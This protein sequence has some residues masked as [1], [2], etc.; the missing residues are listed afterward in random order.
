MNKSQFPPWRNVKPFGERRPG[1]Q[2]S[3]CKPGHTRTE[4]GTERVQSSDQFSLGRPKKAPLHQIL[5]TNWIFP[6]KKKKKRGE[7]N[8]WN[9]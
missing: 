7:R 1:S 6:G 9:T 3:P 2:L 4:T 8:K 5:E